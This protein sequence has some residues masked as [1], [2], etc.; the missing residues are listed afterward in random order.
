MPHHIGLTW[1]RGFHAY[2][3]GTVFRLF[4]IPC[5]CTLGISLLGFIVTIPPPAKAKPSAP[6][7]REYQQLFT[8]DL[9]E[10]KKRH[11][12]RVL[13]AYSKTNFFLVKGKPHGFEYELLQQ[14]GKFI[15]KKVS[16][17]KIRT[18]IV[19]IPLPFDQLIPGLVEGKGD[20][21]AAGLTITPERQKHI[22]FTHPSIPR[23]EEIVVARNKL[24]GMNHLKDLSG[25]TVF[26]I[27]GG[28]YGTHLRQLNTQLD[29]QGL[30]PI[31][32]V[33]ASEYLATE[34]LLELANAGV[35]NLTIADRHI[36]ELWASVLP[37]I[38]AKTDLKIHTGGKIAWAVRKNNQE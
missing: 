4:R 13:V 5:L 31:N 19:F 22:A 11:L 30:S 27:K 35:I 37:N 38:V 25:R 28:S 32:I 34:D 15:N 33:E 20:I 2:N 8:G 17:R 1:Y 6:V 14:Y 12:V 29:E 21:A 3:P 36:A 26:I 16:R 9:P 10:M 23:V 24:K 18:R 7:P